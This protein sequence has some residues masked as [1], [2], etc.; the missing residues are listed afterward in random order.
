M[1]DDCFSTR[2][3]LNKTHLKY[4][5]QKHA[6]IFLSFDRSAFRYT[7]THLHRHIK[8]VRAPDASQSTVCVTENLNHIHLALSHSVR[9]N[10]TPVITR[11]AKSESN[12][13]DTSS[14]I[15]P[16]CASNWIGRSKNSKHC[17][18][19]WCPVKGLCDMSCS[20]PA[21]RC[22]CGRW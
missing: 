11:S 6:Y 18:P 9:R 7:N 13:Y 19:C 21:P 22:V 15:A 1:H 4:M 20:E 16:S 5:K 8:H 2:K 10:R 3:Y 17:R 14:S 12:E